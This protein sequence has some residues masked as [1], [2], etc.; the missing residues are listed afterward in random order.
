MKCK[1]LHKKLI[2]FLE[3]DL[4]ENEAIEMKAHLAECE[5]CAAF[6]EDMQ[7]TLGIIQI[8]K[9]PEVNPFFYTRL[10]AR[11]ENEKVQEKQRV[12]FPVWEKVLQPAFFSL[13]LLAGIYTG[14]KIGQPATAKTSHSIFAETELVPFLNEMQTEPIETFLME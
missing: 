7:K 1:T 6:A 13:L 2:F 3:D 11:M 8:E 4:P 5:S 9:S 12:G 14:I 10:K